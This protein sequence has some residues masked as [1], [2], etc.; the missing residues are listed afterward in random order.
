MDIFCFGDSH[1]RYF[2]KANTLGWAGIA[3]GARPHVMAFDYVAASAKGFAAGANSR[4]AYRKFC[5]DY[6][7]AAPDYVCLAYGQV[8]AEVGYYFRKY[9]KGFGGS[10]EA[11]LSSVFDDY[12]RMAEATVPLRPLVFKGPNPS[13]LRINTQLL[14]Y[15]YQRLVVR[16]NR[17][18]ERTAIWN[19]MQSRPPEVAEHGRINCLAAE[20]LRA[21]VEAAGHIYFDIRPEVEDPQAP[22]MARW[23]HVPADSDVHLCDSFHVRRAHAERLFAVFE[24]LV[25]TQAAQ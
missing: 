14:R 25:V 2:K 12:I 7:A 8:D 17:E 13:T 22:G 11:D 21:K 18:A 23:E 20:L 15:A 6:E 10:A 9:V 3:S 4:F 1:S 24:G 19:D 16:I 5:R